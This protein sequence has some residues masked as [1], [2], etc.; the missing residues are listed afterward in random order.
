M[1]GFIVNPV[2]G[3]G[4][5]LKTWRLLE[6]NLTAKGIS[7]RV[8][9]TE[10]ARDAIR[11]TASFAVDSTITTIVAVG[12]DGTVHECANGIYSAGSDKPLGYIP[13]G[14]GND[15]ARGFG[16][17]SH[18]IDAL[19]LIIE[20]HTILQADLIRYNDRIAIN[21]VGI[22]FDG[23]I[24]LVTNTAPYKRWLNRIKL[25]KVAYV[26]SLI[27][28]LATYQPCA[29]TLTVDGIEQ[30]IK[31]V[32]LIAVANIPYY[33]GGMM[34]CPQANPTNGMI[35]MCVVS[36]IGRFELLT[37]FPR[38]YKGTH[39]SH[40]AVKLL[41]AS[42]I[43][44]HSEHALDIHMDGET[45]GTTPVELEVIPAAVKIVVPTALL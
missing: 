19:N 24:A 16:I 34:I 26:I 20:E 15:F 41:Q 6:T 18:P 36:G 21:S 35:E 8:I 45:A 14:S 37:V 40:R 11:H 3:N 22:G 43:R 31:D 5:G 38:V 2:S 32:W 17:P 4:K 30:H 33:G 10:A 13:A 44:V 1:I 9:F 12:G 27:R 42:Q 39:T 29:V 23:R 25:G 28:V 7:Y